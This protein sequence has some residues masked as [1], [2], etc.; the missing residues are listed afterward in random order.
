M[1][2]RTLTGYRAAKATLALVVEQPSV[3]P[4]TGYPV[5][6]VRA[7]IVRDGAFLGCATAN[8][9]LEIL[10]QFLTSHRASP[11][12]T[13]VIA[14]ASEGT[15]IAYPDLR[16][17]L[18]INNGRTELA[19]LDTIADDDVREAS[20]LRSKTN[21]DD[22]FFRSP[23]N[24]EEI[25]ASFTRLPDS[26]GRPWE[27]IVLTPTDDFVGTLKQTKREM[28]FLIA[29]L[30]AAELLL[31]YFFSRR[32]SRPIEGVSLELRSVKDLTFS[33]TAPASSNIREIKEL[34]SA[35][36]LFETSLRSFSSFVPLDVV[37]RADKDRNPAD[38]RR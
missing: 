37:Q 34:Q 20:R 17:A 3:N 8:I 2:V 38:A 36:S 23:R 21:S 24:G 4:D 16:K 14:N 18:R 29:A 28:I 32:L 19:R 31:I 25:S 27:V 11:R 7:P 6:F 12:S 30:T 35:V 1:D 15:V 10:S 26:F 33:R 22:F 13:T 5:I 9:T